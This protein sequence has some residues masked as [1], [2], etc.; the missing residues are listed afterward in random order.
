MLRNRSRNKHGGQDVDAGPAPSACASPTDESQSDF[1]E[2]ALA[3]RKEA[4]R[5]GEYFTVD[6][7]LREIDA[8]HAK[9]VAD[10]AQ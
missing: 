5:T 8:R 6:E 3:A 10:S 7:V 2:R 4:R 9:A 1:I